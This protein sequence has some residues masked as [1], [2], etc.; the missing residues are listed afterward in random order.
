MTTLD[1]RVQ[2]ARDL[3]Y[4]NGILGAVSVDGSLVQFASPQEVVEFKAGIA[5]AR[6]EVT[7]AELKLHD[8]VL[9]VPMSS[10]VAGRA[11]E[12]IASEVAS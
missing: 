8:L 6:R 11:A 5:R 10:A 1:L 12:F 2:L 3:A 9:G 7:A 4:V